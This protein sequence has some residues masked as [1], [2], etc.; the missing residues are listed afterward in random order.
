[1]WAGG[2][3]TTNAT[4]AA[5]AIRGQLCGYQDNDDIRFL[6]LSQD[7]SGGFYACASAS[8]PDLLSTAT[9]LFILKCYGVT[10]RF[11]ATDF[12]NAHW[13]SSGGFGATLMDEAG[14]VEYTFYG[15]LA[16]GAI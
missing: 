15:L 9:A 16:L 8:I 2:I 12:I 10:P 5:L 6:M 3:A 14:D 13:L 1:L 7:E 4:V 11:D